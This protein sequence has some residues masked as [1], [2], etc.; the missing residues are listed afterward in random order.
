MAWA[1]CLGPVLGPHPA[2]TRREQELQSSLGVDLG[3]LAKGSQH[4]PPSL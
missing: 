3:W 1:C 4:T 2:P